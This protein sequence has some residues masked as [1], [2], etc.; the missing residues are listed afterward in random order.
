MKIFN[1]IISSQGV[2]FVD[3][4]NHKLS[5]NVAIAKIFNRFFSVFLDL[6]LY[7]L[8]I[9]GYIPSHTIRKMFYLLAGVKMGHRAAIHMGARFYQPS[10]IEIGEGT[11]IGDHAFLDGRAPIKIGKHVDIAS[12][13]MIYNSEHNLSDP[14]FTATEES[15]TI[16]D[17]VFIGPRTVILPGVKVG[18]G[19]RTGALVR[20]I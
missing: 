6:E 7:L 14:D 9:I 19:A 10:K 4:N 13:V 3:K 1:L 20:V 16:G 11:I 15:V 12:E 18:D 8:W 17:Y 2:Y 5:L